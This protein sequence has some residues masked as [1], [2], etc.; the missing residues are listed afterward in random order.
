VPPEGALLLGQDDRVGQVGAGLDGALRYVHGPVGPRVPG[1][2]HAV[3]THGN[4][5]VSRQLAW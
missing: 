2:V 1:L 5:N 4:F 3:P